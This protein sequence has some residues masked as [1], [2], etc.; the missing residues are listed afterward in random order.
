[1]KMGPAVF[2]GIVLVIIGL[3]MV[4]KIIFNVSLFRIF[5]GIFIIFIGIR[6]LFGPKIFPVSKKHTDTIFEEKK[7]TS[8]AGNRT[9]YN[10]VFGKSAYDFRN[11]DISSD[12][13]KKIKINIVFGSAKIRL[14]KEVPYLVKT[15]TIFGKSKLPNGNTIHFGDL[16]Y[17]NNKSDSSRLIVHTS[18]VFGSLDIVQD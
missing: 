1:M 16:E 12:K 5:F 15:E 13:T 17:S 2:W 9:E 8:V 14:N 6:I 4:F 18:V 7:Y 11:I 10:V 3:S